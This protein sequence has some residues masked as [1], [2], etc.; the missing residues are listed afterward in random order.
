MSMQLSAV[1]LATATANDP[2]FRLPERPCLVEGLVLAWT[3]TGLLVEGTGTRRALSG[4]SA[5]QILPGLLPLLDGT[6]ALPEL[7]ELTQL[8]EA[9]IHAVLLLLYSCGMLQEGPHPE[10]AR[11]DAAYA[12]LSRLLDT[13]RVN[14]SVAEAQTRLETTTA[15]VVAPE[16]FAGT[17]TAHLRASGMT[18]TAGSSV[19]AVDPATGLAVVWIDR[20]CEAAATAACVAHYRAGIPVLLVGFDVAGFSLGPYSA[21]DHGACPACCL[22]SWQL[23]LPD[24]GRESREIAAALTAIEVVAL[25]SRVGKPLSIHGRLI[26][27]LATGRSDTALS[28]RRP[29]C[30]ECGDPAVLLSEPPLAF[31]FE[32]S[33]AFPAR[34][35]ANPRDHQHHFEA[36]NVALQYD[37]K[38]AGGRPTLELPAPRRTREPISPGAADR[39]RRVSRSDVATVLSLAFGLKIQ[40]LEHQPIQRW[41]PTGGNLG[42]PQAYLVA[43]DVDGIEPGVYAYLPVGHQLAVLSDE[44]PWT[45]LEGTPATV[46]MTG[47]LM[48]VAKKY[49]TFAYRVVHLDAG[50][51]LSHAAFAAGVVDVTLVNHPAWDD[52]LLAR[53]TRINPDIEIVTGMFDLR[54]AR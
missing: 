28:A 12:L 8:D 39:P 46:I 40:L 13:T 2:Q 50:A 38:D 9:R 16:P 33:V 37:T 43:H 21:V 48:R 4:K 15:I 20:D 49:R 24:L 5:Q 44:P 35:L 1:Q 42:S 26:T 6:R 3:A 30:P 7:A 10:P 53:A 34:R 23:G 29:G 47:A 11:R 27:D 14:A 54:T 36:P 31:R 51:A 19:S 25:V 18:T 22:S 41:A 32:H 45:Q 52:E 17:L